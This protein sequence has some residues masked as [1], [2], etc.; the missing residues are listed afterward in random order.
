MQLVNVGALCRGMVMRIGCQYVERLYG[1]CFSL[2]CPGYPGETLGNGEGGHVMHVETVLCLLLTGYRD[3][4]LLSI[5]S[6]CYKGNFKYYFIRVL[7]E[8]NQCKFSTYWHIGYVSLQIEKS[9]QV[10][11]V[12]RA[13]RHFFILCISTF[14]RGSIKGC[15]AWESWGYFCLF[16]E[17]SWR[18]HM[19]V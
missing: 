19:C 15:R 6:G 4:Y 8:A 10:V 16:W 11:G 14:V 12:H 5:S 9:I 2:V 17:L 7:L 18:S 3:L 13:P 1:K